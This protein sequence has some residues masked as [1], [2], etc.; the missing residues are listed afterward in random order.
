VTAADLQLRLEAPARLALDEPLVA[1][2]RLAT[3]AGPVT[4]SSRLNLIEGDLS[5]VVTGPGSHPVRVTWPYP[6]DSGLRQ[7]TLTA[8]E[9]LEGGVLLLAASGREPLFPIAGVYE[10]VAEFTPTPATTVTAQPVTVV[11]E[12][13]VEA[14]GRARARALAEPAVMGSLMSASVAEPAADALAGPVA[15]T[16]TGRLL[17]ALAAGD[18]AEIRDA[19]SA[20]ASAAGAVA[21]ATIA[22]AVLP[23]GLFP[24]DERLVAVAAAAG[25]QDDDGRAAALLAE[26]PWRPPSG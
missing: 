10:L 14:E 16:P 26:H 24:G 7:V 18:P 1:L 15:A 2:A 12:D 22:V 4:T 25:A 11:R 5:V 19:A 21:P 6:V 23:P 9:V 13:P 3:P 17:A 8:G 20:L